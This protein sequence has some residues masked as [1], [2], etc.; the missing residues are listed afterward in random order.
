V[1]VCD[2]YWRNSIKVLTVTPYF[3]AQLLK[4][5]SFRHSWYGKTSQIK[6]LDI[7]LL[8]ILCHV[9]AVKCLFKLTYKQTGTVHRY[10]CNVENVMTRARYSLLCVQ[11]IT[12][13]LW[14]DN[15]LSNINRGRWGRWREGEGRR[16]VPWETE[17]FL[18]LEWNFKDSQKGR[19]SH[20]LQNSCMRGAVF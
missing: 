13:P 9:N 2:N 3:T 1:F 4:Q 17:S 7:N 10:C 14:T 12:V 6:M 18:M 8:Y 16:E 20:G 19:V 11:N 5:R 15:I